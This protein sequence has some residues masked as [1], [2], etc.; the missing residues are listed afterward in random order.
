[1]D[2]ANG[3]R[4]DVS[5]ELQLDCSVGIASTRIAARI[6]SRMARPRGILLCRD[7]HETALI[8]GLPLHQL[9]ELRPA[10]LARLR[11]EGIRTFWQLASLGSMEARAF[12][13]SEGAILVSLVRGEDGASDETIDGRLSRAASLLARRLSRRL[14]RRGRDARGLELQLI[15][16]DGVTSE[17]YLL[18]PRAT[19]FLEEI[20]E[21]AQRLVEMHPRRHEPI[22]NVALTATGL[23]GLQG[24]LDLA[25]AAVPFPLFGQEL[26]REVRVTLGGGSYDE[27]AASSMG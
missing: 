16:T 13:G 1:M 3:L 20:L 18:L 9:D 11:S 23:I 21:A 19:S 14:S 6:C 7:G 17:R 12:L 15:Y 22:A 2:W 4:E 27:T 8:G 10:Q 26:P 24:S 5:R 25:D